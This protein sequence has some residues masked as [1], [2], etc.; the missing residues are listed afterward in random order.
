MI[1]IVCQELQSS[2]F[3]ACYHSIQV[4]FLNSKRKKEK[5]VLNNN[6]EPFFFFN[7]KQTEKKGTIFAQRVKTK[8]ARENWTKTIGG[9]K[10]DLAGL[11]EQW[12]KTQAIIISKK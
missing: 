7:S 4:N 3:R 12:H 1:C 6:I 10:I 5:K 2:E 8:N 9:T 11:I